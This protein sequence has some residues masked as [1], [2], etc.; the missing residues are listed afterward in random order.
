MVSANLES[1][2]GLLG[3]VQDLPPDPNAR[4][5]HLVKRLCELAEAQ[6][7]V[8]LCVPG[9]KPQDVD[10][11]AKEMT[12]VGI[13]PEQRRI[14]RGGVGERLIETPL[15]EAL[16]DRTH[17]LERGQILVASRDELTGE[18]PWRNPAWRKAYRT[19][20]L[21]PA[22]YALRWMPSVRYYNLLMLYR[23]WGQTPFS[24]SAR[25]LT[26]Q[27]WSSAGWLVSPMTLLEQTGVPPNGHLPTAPADLSRRLRQVYQL[28]LH[29]QDAAGIAAHLNL[30]IHTVYEH[31]QRLYR[32]LGVRNRTE[33][34]ARHLSRDCS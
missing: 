13:S 19:C 25:E 10:L 31:M 22:L 16:A 21:E 26:R 23:K 30:S 28:L 17:R 5:M 27:F 18:P 20:G 7:A 12:L 32:R 33:L 3:E 15:L 29:G 6:A 34:L 24:P 9:L 14:L 1:L 8:L 4:K 2:W 11:Y